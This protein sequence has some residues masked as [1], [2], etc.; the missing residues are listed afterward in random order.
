MRK[1]RKDKINIMRNRVLILVVVFIFKL[2]AQTRVPSEQYLR[3][4]LLKN[5]ACYDFEE[6]LKPHFSKLQYGAYISDILNNSLVFDTNEFFYTYFKDTLIT[7]NKLNSIKLIKYTTTLSHTI[8]HKERVLRDQKNNNI[9]EDVILPGNQD[10]KLA[11]KG[12]IGIDTM[13]GRI[14]FISGYLY[15]DDIKALF[16]AGKLNEVKLHQYVLIKYYNYSPYSIM[17]KQNKVKFKSKINF[18]EN[19]R[20][21]CVFIDFKNGKYTEAL[22]LLK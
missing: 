3:A 16:F 20:E 22:R 15:A 14:L 18:N 5:I 17:I 12:L 11:D 8:I 9:N 21:Y 7:I 10:L 2:N 13:T 4:I 1:L 19:E 6:R